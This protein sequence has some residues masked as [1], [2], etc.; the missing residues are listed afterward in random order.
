[1]VIVA[2]SVVL[3]APL[4]PIRAVM[5]PVAATNDALSTAR[6]PPKCFETFSTRSNGSAMAS[7]RLWLASEAPAQRGDQPGDAARREGHHR[8]EHAS[9]NDEIEAGC[10][11]GHEFGDF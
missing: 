8:D 1:P 11:A 10:V 7:L 6:R 9:V 3:P 4:G 2:N 5:L